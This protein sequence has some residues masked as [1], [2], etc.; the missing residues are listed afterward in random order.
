MKLA[1]EFDDRDPVRY[2]KLHKVG[3]RDL[4]DPEPIGDAASLAQARELAEAVAFWGDGETYPYEL[5]N[6]VRF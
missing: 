3:C 2:G 1:I 5:A 4:R 6:C